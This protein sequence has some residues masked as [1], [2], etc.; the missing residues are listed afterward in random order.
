MTDTTI[1]PFSFPAVGRK[2][3]PADFDGG[4]L[5]SDGG[6]MLLAMAERRLGIADRLARVFPDR[7]DPSRITHT[8]ADMIRARAFA[9]ACGYEDADDLD[10][11]RVDPAFKLACGRL[12]ETGANLCSQPTLSRLE[13]APSLKDAIRLTYALVDQ[14]MASYGRE[15]ASVILDIDDTCD[16]VHGHQ[17]LS[18]FNAHYDERCFLP[19][20]IY[21]TERSRPV[22][23]VLR[24]GKTPSGV[25]VRAHLR[26]LVRHVRKQWTKTRITFRG[27]GHYARPEAMAWCEDN[28]IDY[29]FGLPGS[30]PLSRK[31]DDAADA[32]RTERAVSDKPVVRDYAETRHKAKSWNR[33][34][35]AVARIEATTLGLD[36]RFVVTNLGYGSPEWIYDSLYCARGQAENLIKLHKTQLASDRTSCHSAVANQVRLVLHT[37]AYWLMLTVRDAIPKARDLAKAEFATLRLRLI[38]IAARVVE[39]TSRVRLAFAACCPEADLFRGLPGALAPLGP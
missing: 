25:E 11:L 4:R 5:T 27:D 10:S 14:W 33:E 2:K 1:L 30:K 26:R 22:A 20:H 18:L 28:G 24:P 15:P 38:K 12:P 3:L 39:T 35:R 34:R 8:L 13:N 36:I 31:V 16:V 17:Q 23:V 7:R 32:V 29:V 9:I 6:V 21:D 19:I 37:A